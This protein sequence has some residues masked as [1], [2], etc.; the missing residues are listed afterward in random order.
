[1]G[2]SE[3]NLPFAESAFTRYLSAMSTLVEI[4][5]AITHLG[6]DEKTALSLW[7]Q[8]LTAPAMSATDEQRLLRS[9]DEAIRDVDSGQG[10][11]LE[12]ARK[13]VASWAGG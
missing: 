2:E 12:D 6:E 7:L 11:P 5:E 10:V 9:L 3:W 4:Q 1:M 13:L 8:S